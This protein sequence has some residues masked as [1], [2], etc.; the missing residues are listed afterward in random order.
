MLKYGGLSLGLLLSAMNAWSSTTD[1][2]TTEEPGSKKLYCQAIYYMDANR[3]SKIESYE[4]R[5][6]CTLQVKDAQRQ[7]TYH[8]SSKK[9]SS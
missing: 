6:H 4:L 2:C 3:C 7:V 8:V 1:P 9:Q 5:Q